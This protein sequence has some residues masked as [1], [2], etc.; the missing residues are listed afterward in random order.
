M[1][2]IA[3]T[4]SVVLGLAFATTLFAESLPLPVRS[5]IAQNVPGGHELTGLPPEPEAE[6]GTLI[7]RM[8]LT[9]EGRRVFLSARPLVVDDLGELCGDGPHPGEGDDTLVTL[10]CYRHS[11]RIF[12]LRGDGLFGQATTITTAAHELLHAVYARLTDSERRRLGTLLLAEISRLDADD[13]LLR[14]IDASV[15]DDERARATEQFAYLGSQAVLPG[16][17][18]DDL[19]AL[20]ARWFADREGLA[21]I[22]G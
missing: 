7:E 20:Y 9:E 10:G 8:S 1:S 17:F 2:R 22:A 5:W 13:P 14:Q 4:V 3:L 19:E 18:S 21:R 11:D 16:G 15:G 6:I 12:I